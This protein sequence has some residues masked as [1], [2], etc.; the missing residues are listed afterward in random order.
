MTDLRH[1][2]A[3]L[4]DV[5]LHYVELGEGPLVVLLH[6]FPEFWYGWHRQLA[7]LANAG[8]RVVVPD[9]RG[10][11]TSSKPPG[12]AAYRTGRLAADVRALIREGGAARARVAGHD[13]GGMVAYTL[14]AEHPEAVERLAILNAP[15]PRVF[16]RR[17]LP[18]PRQIVRSWYALLFQMPW[19]P[20]RALRAGNWRL[21][22]EGMRRE[23]RPGAFSDDDLARYVEAWSQPGAIT[24]MLHYYRAAL[25]HP[26]SAA[27]ADT[28]VQAPVRV[29]WGERDPHLLPSLAEPSHDDVP[30]LESVIRLPDAS[31]WLQHDQPERV[32]ALLVEFFST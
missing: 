9:L 22:R 12:V 29:I 24:A 30:G 32:A 5:R 15:H 10:Y 27:M 20:E 28:P 11:N 14:A 4:G 17:G 25:R 8:F 26:P 1:A 6:G 2:D 31:H 18:D 23:A 13:W 21:L 7:P 3:D 16:A 19:L